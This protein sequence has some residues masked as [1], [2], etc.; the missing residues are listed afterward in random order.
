MALILKDI[1]KD[2]ELPDGGTFRA[3]D[4]VNLEIAQG[5]FC[6][7]L[8]PSGC[9]KTTLLRLIAG[10]EEPTRG[11]IFYDGMDLLKVPPGR[12]GFPLVF[13]SYALFPH[14][15][16]WQNIA[17]GLQ[18]KKM[19]KDL[20][21]SKVASII[22]MIGLGVNAH[23]HPKSL[24]GG[25]QQRTALARALVTEPRIILFDEPLSNLDAKLRVS[26]RSE[27]RA[28]Q[29]RLGITAVYVTHDQEEAMAVSDR[30]VVLNRGRIEQFA[31]PAEVYRC[32]ASRFVAD[33]IG[34]ANILKIQN[35]SAGK[36]SLLGR[37][38]DFPEGSGGDAARKKESVLVRPEAIRLSRTE[39]KHSGRVKRAT[40]LGSKTLYLVESSGI[41]LW[42]EVSGEIDGGEFA[43]GGEV[44]F[45]LEPASF[46]FL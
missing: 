25:E 11:E 46:H 2:F 1:V 35:G 22:D 32:P 5:E 28:L 19:S 17:F 6:T 43:E 36:F 41:E 39:G 37:N 34:T 26:M 38:Y 13:Q 29:K 31:S 20:V 21:K 24:S 45:D 4:G 12:R 30:I 14:M 7:F 9:G 16:V 10:F 42:A 3:V 33:F 8:G 18:L 23:K 40:F 44:R 15:T 27:I